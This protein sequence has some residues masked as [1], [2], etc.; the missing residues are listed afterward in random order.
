MVQAPASSPWSR[1]SQAGKHDTEAR[2]KP[3]D[4][5]GPAQAGHYDYDAATG[6]VRLKAGRHD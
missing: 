6:T 5:R 4:Q 3:A 2:R 1:A